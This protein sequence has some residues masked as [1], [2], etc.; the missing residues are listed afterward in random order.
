MG[1]LFWSLVGLTYHGARLIILIFLVW[2]L[3]TGRIEIR[4]VS[5]KKKEK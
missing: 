4:W 2:A 1:D 3:A 5:K